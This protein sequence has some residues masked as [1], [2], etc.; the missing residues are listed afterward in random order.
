[1][2]HANLLNTVIESLLFILIFALLPILLHRV[3]A[4][5]YKTLPERYRLYV[6][7]LTLNKF[8]PWMT[9]HLTDEQWRQ[10]RRSF[11]KEYSPGVGKY[12]NFRG[13]M[14]GWLKCEGLPPITPEM[15]AEMQERKIQYERKLLADKQQA[16]IEA[17]ET[18]VVH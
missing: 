15:A 10:H 3:L 16:A 8:R 2:V 7:D 1:M 11:F 17:I 12:K 14:V 9:Q 18:P 6:D 5:I 13:G 4:W